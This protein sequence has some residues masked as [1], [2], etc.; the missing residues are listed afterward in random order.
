MAV[1]A[2]TLH[3]IDIAASANSFTPQSRLL[4]FGV[5]LRFSLTGDPR[6]RPP[7][8]VSVALIWIGASPLSSLDVVVL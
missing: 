6:S 7:L 8:L 2:N 4:E 1:P 5:F 3:A